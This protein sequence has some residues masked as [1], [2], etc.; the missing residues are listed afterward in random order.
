VIVFVNVF[1]KINARFFAD[2]ILSVAEGLRMTFSLE[3]TFC[4]SVTLSAAKGLDCGPCQGAAC[5]APT[6]AKKGN[7]NATHAD[8]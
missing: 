8:M 6:V 1:E 5:C 7:K 4:T 3:Q 2:F